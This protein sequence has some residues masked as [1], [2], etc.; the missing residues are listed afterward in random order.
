[1]QVI[2]HDRYVRLFE[3]KRKSQEFVP[4]LTRA[5]C[6]ACPVRAECLDYALEIQAV[7]VWAGTHTQDRVYIRRARKAASQATTRKWAE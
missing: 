7:G 1:M 3:A 6:G 2:D 5:F 4:W